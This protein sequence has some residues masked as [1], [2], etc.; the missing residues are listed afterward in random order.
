MRFFTL[1]CALMVWATS[2]QA[3]ELHDDAFRLSQIDGVRVSLLDYA[4]G[5]CW[6]NLKEV[7]DYAEEKLRIKGVKINDEIG[8][9]PGK[10]YVLEISVAA[11]RLYQDGSGPCIGVA[12]SSLYTVAFIEGKR[13]IAEIAWNA[14][15]KA[16]KQNFNRHTIKITAELIGKLQR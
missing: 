7:R 4:K 16:E 11:G 3:Q 15:L 1:I 13:H 5:A 12:G 14:S 8:M 10:D 2:S 9:D 6:T